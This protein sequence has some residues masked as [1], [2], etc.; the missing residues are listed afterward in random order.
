MR[1]LDNDSSYSLVADFN[2]SMND[3]EV[4]L[5]LYLPM[6]GGK[7][8]SLYRYFL[9]S[10]LLKEEEYSF[11]T[12]DLLSDL[13]YDQETFLDSLRRLEALG[14]I[15]TFYR[16]ASQ[17]KDSHYIYKLFPP[18]TPRKFFDDIIL[19]SLL[20]KMVG[21][22]RM[23]RLKM[24][25]L[26]AKDK[27]PKGYSELTSSFKEVFSLEDIEKEEDSE[28]IKD[29]NYKAIADIDLATLKKA[30]KDRKIPLSIFSKNIKDVRD[31]IALYMIPLNEGVEI[32][33]K[34]IDS[35]GVFY[36]EE[37]KKDIR[38]YRSYLRDDNTKDDNYKGGKFYQILTTISPE[39][40]LSIR[41]NAKAP[42]YMLDEIEKIKKE[43]GLPNAL[44]NVV[45]DYSFRK[46]DNRFVE[47]Y[48]EKVAYSI[49]SNNITS[50]YEAMTFLN[51][52]D[53][54][55]KNEKKVKVDNKGEEKDDI[56]VKSLLDKVIS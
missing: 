3:E 48:I 47:L 18:A 56:D 5:L 35:A 13:D 28:M 14:L 11:L 2:L 33:E 43:T 54:R 17:N 52:Q 25:F 51:E 39:Q 34:N 21:E 46:T 26:K 27:K 31:L 44:I 32:I 53:Y 29:K 40:Y 41:L 42:A 9:S 20:K 8:Y 24:I 12:I 15:E 16:Q 38:S 30:L 36:F 23:A 37:F 10:S 1:F 6:M 50:P 55:M 4:L 22:K 45:L 19:S 7:A 49:L